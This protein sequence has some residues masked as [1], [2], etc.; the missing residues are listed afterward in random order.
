MIGLPLVRFATVGSPSRLFRVSVAD[1]LIVIPVVPL[2][3]PPLPVRMVF[4]VFRTVEPLNVL[5]AV[6]VKVPLLSLTNWL[7]AEP[8]PLTMALLIR[9][10]PV[11]ASVNRRFVT[12][13]DR[14]TPP[15]MVSGPPVRLLTSTR[16]PPLLVTPPPNSIGWAPLTTA[17]APPRITGFTKLFAPVN[18]PTRLVCRVPPLKLKLPPPPSAPTFASTKVPCVSVVPPR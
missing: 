3:R 15:E 4:P 10:L 1:G 13:P 9:V 16:L 8:P 12:S 2:I 11:P 6:S 17:W 14:L 5:S 18:P 7:A